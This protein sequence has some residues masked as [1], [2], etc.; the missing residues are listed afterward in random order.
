MPVGDVD[1]IGAETTDRVRD[2]DNKLDAP[3]NICVRAFGFPGARPISR[4]LKRHVEPRRSRD[5]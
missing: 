3:H 2:V 5:I 4:M 1:R